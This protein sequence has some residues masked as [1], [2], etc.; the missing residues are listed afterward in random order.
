MN[1]ILEIDEIGQMFGTQFKLFMTWYDFRLKFYNMK[2]N[3]DM[4]T[5][6]KHEKSIIWVPQLV[7]F[8]TEEKENTKNDN[9][10]QIIARRDSNY[11][12]SEDSVQ[13]NIF[14]FE[15]K[16]NPLILTILKG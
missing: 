2:V 6:T 12:R 3:M 4:N 15:G 16:E 5:L 1:A 11:T 9:K 8:N 7:F 14:I 10:A 13:D